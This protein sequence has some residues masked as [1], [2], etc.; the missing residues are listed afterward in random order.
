MPEL[1]YKKK[2]V[3]EYFA[4]FTG[5]HLCWSGSLFNKV[6]GLQ[7]SNFSKKSLQQLFFC[8]CSAILKNTYFEEH[9]RTA[10]F[11]INMKQEDLIKL[12]GEADLCDSYKTASE[13][14]GQLQ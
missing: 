8:E 1:H 7:A 12:D 9:L 6:V 4:I 13:K 14:R 10:S 2:A 5:K 11:R 3:Y